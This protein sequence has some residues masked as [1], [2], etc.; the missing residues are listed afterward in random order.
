MRIGGPDQHAR[1]ILVWLA[2]SCALTACD[3]PPSP[4]PPTPAR[5]TAGT[6]SPE[7][8]E[9]VALRARPL[10]LPTLTAGEVCPVTL[11]APPNPP[12]P[13]GH[14]LSTGGPP[15]ALGHAPVFPDA[16]YFHGG[17]Q[18]RVSTNAVRPGWYGAKAPWASRSGYLDATEISDALALNV[19]ADWQFWPGSTE[20]T[21]PGCYGYQVD[22]SDFTEMIV[23]RV[24]L[25]TPG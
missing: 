9:L 17:T 19:Q 15:G 24:E 20:V 25:A 8:A 12:P 5:P 14:P 22:G 2:L 6:A 18:L 3:P 1:H 4:T 13:A 7:P 23:F 21:S 10:L 16:R 11:P